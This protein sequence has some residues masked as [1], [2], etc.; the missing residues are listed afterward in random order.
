M[1]SVELCKQLATAREMGE[2]CD[3]DLV[4]NGQKISVHKL[5]IYSQSPVIKAACTGAFVEASGTY[6]IKDST[7]ETVQ[8]MVDYLYSGGYAT[9]ELS[10]HIKIFSLADKYLISGLLALAETEFREAVLAEQDT[11]ALLQCIPEVYELQSES[12]NKLREI[13]AEATRER[14]GAP[15][16]TDV[17]GSL[18]SVMDAVPEFAIDIVRSFMQGTTLGNNQFGNGT[19]PYARVI[20]RSRRF[21]QFGI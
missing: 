7:F 20:D 10:L 4:C 18:N 1:Y 15:L 8:R 9:T 3:L 11:C 6:E 13:V 12:S 5:I 16:S 2:L 19:S 17:Q 14:M 21:G